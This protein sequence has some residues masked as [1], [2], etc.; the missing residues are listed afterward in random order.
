[1]KHWLL[2]V[3]LAGLTVSCDRN[4]I[5]SGYFRLRDESPLPAWVVLPAGTTRDQVNV[6]ITIY[7]ATTTPQWKVRFEIRDKRRCFF[8]TIQEELGYGYWHPDSE[9]EK[10]PAGTFPNW[11]IIEVKG[12]KEVYEQSEHDHRDLLKIVKK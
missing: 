8:K 7:E 9:R 3:A 4:G 2:A 1:M 10:A 11:M 6:R 5:V 12:T